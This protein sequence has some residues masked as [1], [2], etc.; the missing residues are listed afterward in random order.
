MGSKEPSRGGLSV[1][2]KPETR[3]LFNGLWN[4]MDVVPGQCTFV[5]G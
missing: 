1:R 5:F 2:P 3:F 4:K